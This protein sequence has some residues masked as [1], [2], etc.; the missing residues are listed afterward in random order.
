MAD[1]RPPTTDHRPLRIVDRGS[2]IAVL[3]YSITGYYRAVPLSPPFAVRR[4]ARGRDVDN[5]TL[6]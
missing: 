5:V 1:D 4:R 2:R 6:F 3:H